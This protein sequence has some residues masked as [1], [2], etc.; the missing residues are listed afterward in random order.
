VGATLGTAWGG[1]VAGDR[2]LAPEGARE[3]AAA[4]AAPTSPSS[5]SA[6]SASRSWRRLGYRAKWP[7]TSILSA[8]PPAA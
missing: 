6:G 7:S 3:A 8:S 4:A 2:R 1:A 5:R